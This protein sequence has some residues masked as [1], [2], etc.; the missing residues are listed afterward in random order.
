MLVAGRKVPTIA[1]RI[2]T[3]M[4]GTLAMAE[5]KKSDAADHDVAQTAGSLEVGS[6][7]RPAC[8]GGYADRRRNGAMD[9]HLCKWI[10]APESEQRSNRRHHEGAGDRR[11]EKGCHGAGWASQHPAEAGRE[12]EQVSA[13]REPPEGK[14]KRELFVR[15]PNVACR[16]TPD[17]T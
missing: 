15:Q 4:G 16:P 7:N 9:C 6:G 3:S 10:V 5:S 11:R 12:S 14:A 2:S 8:L 1:A 13:G 17:A